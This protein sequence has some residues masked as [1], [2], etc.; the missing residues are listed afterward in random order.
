MDC[1]GEAQRRHRFGC[2]TRI[3]TPKQKRCCTP[4]STTLRDN[5]RAAQIR[6]RK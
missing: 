4:H 6:K 1:G 2:K 5:A 3:E